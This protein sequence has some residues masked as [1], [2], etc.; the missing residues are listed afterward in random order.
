MPIKDKNGKIYTLHGPNP[1]MKEQQEWDKSQ[2]TL[3][4]IGV[5][6]ETIIDEN[7]PIRK[8]KEN[9]IDIGVEL[10]LSEETRSIP[11]STF[12]QEIAE[13]PVEK[14]VVPE[15]P[16]VEKPV[17][18]KPAPPEDQVIL[19]VDPKV[20]RILRE[21]GVQYHCAPAV[22]ITRHDSL[23][24]EYSSVRY[25]DPFIFDGIIVDQ[26]DFQIQIWSIRLVP[27]NSIIYRKHPEGGERWWKITHTEPKT[28]GHIA[29]GMISDLNPSF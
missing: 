7:S 22:G 19:N 16:V 10:N 12:L 23:Y 25:G 8:M 18:V 28:G 11:S 3:H 26:S 29:V 21:R 9:L 14:I 24:D 17:I 20:A 6:S 27:K 15:P 2:M 4:N 13:K 1:I 5:K